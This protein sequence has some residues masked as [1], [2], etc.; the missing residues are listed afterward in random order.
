MVKFG[1]IRHAKTR[2]NIEKKIQGKNNMP[3]SPEGIQEAGLWG[4]ILRKE[5]YNLVLASPM[6][7]AEQ[8]A[9]IISHK[10][11]VD[12]EFDRDLREQD[13]GAWEGRRIIDIRKQ[14][15][16]EIEF[17]E[18]KGWKF[19]PPGGESSIKVLKRVSKAMEKAAKNFDEKY[20][21][22]VAHNNVIK[23]TFI[24]GLSPP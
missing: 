13:F 21:L 18:S 24:K 2:W 12:I 1:L 8:T 4:E 15:P 19:C 23:T 7:R 10:I 16:G 14:D 20:V 11:N 5:K 3:L 9:R 22:V 6:M 17:Q